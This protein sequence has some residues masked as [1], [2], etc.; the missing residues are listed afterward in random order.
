MGFSRSEVMSRI[1]GRDTE[2][3]RVLRRLLWNRGLRYRLHLRTPAGRADLVF[4]GPRVAVFVD[5]CFWHGC[6]EHYVRPRTSALFWADK[7]AAN[8]ERDV[9]QTSRLEEAGWRVCRFWEHEVFENPEAVAD[10]IT[11]AVRNQRWRP[12][13]SWRVDQVNVVDSDTDLERRFLRELR[14]REKPRKAIRQ[15]TT[16]KWDRTRSL[17]GVRPR[18]RG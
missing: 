10:R 3:E 12:A 14:D 4:S 6:P 2:P 17:R 13:M 11:R 9:N 7:L 8:V 18:Q 16:R 1:R 15:R 5:G